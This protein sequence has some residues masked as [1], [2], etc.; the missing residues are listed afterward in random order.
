MKKE[1]FKKKIFALIELMRPGN[2]LMA[3]IAI[4]VGYAVSRGGDYSIALI[5]AIA[6]FLICAGG[7]A[8]N[9]YFDAS[10]DA[11]VSK[12]K[13]IPSKRITRKEA[14]WFSIN[15][16]ILG[17][18]LALTINSM[19]SNIAL[20][21]T[22]LLVIYPLFLNKVKYLGN[23]IVA[24]GTA[25][26]FVFGSIATGG[27]HDLVIALAITAFFANMGR[28]ITKDI[29]DL[30][31]DKN[32]KKT[33]PNLIGVNNSKLFVITYYLLAIIAGLGTYILFLLNAYYLIF[34]LATITILFYTTI[35][36]LKNNFIESQKFSKIGMIF[37]I[38]GFVLI[39]I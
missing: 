20:V 21:F 10:I 18:L 39:L 28:E 37:A 29:E 34:I 11:K 6:G 38:I 27:I 33:L 14:L 7:Q 12:H 30:K 17:N 13:P 32:T 24:G 26:T 1:I 22:T 19:T 3:L 15:L 31:K 8:I 4:L 9:D 35:L 2:C 16:F 25:V 23:F 36:L 5:T